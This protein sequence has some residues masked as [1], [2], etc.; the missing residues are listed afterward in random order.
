MPRLERILVPVDAS[1]PSRAA[2]RY[3]VFL[4]E[5]FGA[6]VIALHAW[7]TPNEVPPEAG[8][9][10]PWGLPEGIGA[11]GRDR[12]ERLVAD[13]IAPFAGQRVEIEARIEFGLPG[14]TVKKAAAE[15]WADLIVV[16][17]HARKGFARFVSGSVA[18][19]ILR[20]AHC[21]VL[22]VHATDV[23]AQEPP[24]E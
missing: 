21:P 19:E 24:R 6:K 3:A 20:L 18:E 2:L 5:R 22:V 1:A 15:A 16:G 10:T 11:F 7:Q 17:T 8:P 14:P 13:L 23:A 12:A 9:T 4:A